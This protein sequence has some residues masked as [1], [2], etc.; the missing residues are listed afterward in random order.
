MSATIANVQ[1]WCGA[2]VILVFA[3]SFLT[4]AWRPWSFVGDLARYRLVP[5][6]MNLPL[7]GSILLVEASIPVFLSVRPLRVEGYVLSLVI[8]VCFSAALVTVL[9][10]G[11]R[12]PCGC[13][14]PS[15][16]P[17][18]AAHL[19]RNAILIA[20]SLCGLLLG[21]ASATQPASLAWLAWLPALVA[22]GVT[23]CM[24]V[25]L[26]TLYDVL[27]SGSRIIGDGGHRDHL[28]K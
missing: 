23:A 9:Y 19:A 21:D 18:N 1:V 15:E 26:P 17:V 16:T 22:A 13:L 8:T 28:W 20:T 27:W 12:I 4:K 2:T 3:I 10:R 24:I 14:G 5:T 11:Q 7:A 6:S 25:G